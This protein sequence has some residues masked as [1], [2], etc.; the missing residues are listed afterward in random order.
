MKSPSYTNI[1]VALVGSA[2]IMIADVQAETAVTGCRPHIIAMA[3]DHQLT[4]HE[5]PLGPFD[6]LRTQTSTDNTDLLS[7]SRVDVHMSRH[8]ST[9]PPIGI[10]QPGEEATQIEQRDRGGAFIGKEEGKISQ[11]TT[12]AC[13]MRCQMQYNMCV[14]AFQ[15]LISQCHFQYAN[16]EINCVFNQ[17]GL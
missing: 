15:Q 2:I 8:G 3:D 6:D 9:R 7:K 12:L 16:C 17:L 14:V 4:T 13:V 10:I 1:A 11:F 5:D